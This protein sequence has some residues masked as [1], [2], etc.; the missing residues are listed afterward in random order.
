ME[1]ASRVAA[2]QAAVLQVGCSWVGV[3]GRALDV[4]V[5]RRGSQERRGAGTA[6]L[7]PPVLTRLTVLPEQARS[8][9]DSGLVDRLAADAKLMAAQAD[10][11]ARLEVSARPELFERLSLSARVSEC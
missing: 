7:V 4:R 8:A 5:G 11:A 6:P 10:V 1:P 2:L 9:G 3:R